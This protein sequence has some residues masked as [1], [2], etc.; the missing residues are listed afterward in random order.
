MSISQCLILIYYYQVYHPNLFPCVFESFAAHLLGSETAPQ[1][2]D[3]IKLDL[4]THHQL[5]GWVWPVHFSLK[6]FCFLLGPVWALCKRLPILSAA[7]RS[8]AAVPR[9]VTLCPQLL[10]SGVAFPALPSQSLTTQSGEFHFLSSLIFYSLN[11]F[12][13]HR[14]EKD[15]CEISRNTRVYIC[16]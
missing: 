1:V 15:P 11:E 16:H 8:H 4:T 5:T 7:S 12:F 10:L 13:Q 9:S 6:C 2:R 14:V 3:W